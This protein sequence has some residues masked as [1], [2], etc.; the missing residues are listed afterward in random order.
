MGNF[1]DY[2]T[3]NKIR[4]K[5]LLL[6]ENPLNIC[7]GHIHN[8]CCP[9]H[10]EYSAGLERKLRGLYTYLLSDKDGHPAYYLNLWS[11]GNLRPEPQKLAVAHV[12]TCLVAYVC[13][14]WCKPGP[15]VFLSRAWEWWQSAGILYYNYNDMA[16]IRKMSVYP[17]VVKYKLLPTS[18]FCVCCS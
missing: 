5:L 14:Q 16:L 13:K 4:V 18:C 1:R 9:L 7:W 2:T 11:G 17:F 12:H 3:F 8:D 10:L 6:F 15:F